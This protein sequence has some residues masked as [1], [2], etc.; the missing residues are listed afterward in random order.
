M[1]VVEEKGSL[2][3]WDVLCSLWAPQKLDDGDLTNTDEYIVHG[4]H[5]ECVLEERIVV[6]PT[7]N[8]YYIMNL[9]VDGGGGGFPHIRLLNSL[10]SANLI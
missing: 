2:A 3:R 4:Y 5:P 10:R 8:I 7:R 6:F 9:Q 1:F